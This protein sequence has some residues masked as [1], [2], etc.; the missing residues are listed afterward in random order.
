MARQHRAETEKPMIPELCDPN[1]RIGSQVV[2]RVT[3]TLGTVSEIGHQN[4]RDYWF[5]FWTLDDGNT[6]GGWHDLTEIRLA[7]QVQFSPARAI[8]SSWNARDARDPVGLD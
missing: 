7:D 1:I 6:C 2:H 3:A 4:G 5:V 8:R